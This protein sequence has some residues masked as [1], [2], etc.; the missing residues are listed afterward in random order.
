[1]PAEVREYQPMAN[2]TMA[3]SET[4]FTPFRTPVST[5]GT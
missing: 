4:T 1:M 5:I 2:I 3:P